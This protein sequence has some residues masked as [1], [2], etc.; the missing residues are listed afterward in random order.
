M[1][2]GILA[3]IIVFAVIVLVHEGGHFIAA[4]LMG[5]KVEE[6]AIG[7]GPSIFSFQKGETKY[8]LR[9]IPLGGYNK[10]LGMDKEESDDPKAFS[11]KPVWKR[12]VVIVAGAAFNVILAFVIFSSVLMNTGYQTFPDEPVIGKVLEGTTAQKQGLKVGDRILSIDDK[13]I[14][15]WSDIPSAMEGKANKVVSLKIQ[16]N[17]ET[18][19]IHVIPEIKEGDRPIMGIVPYL[20]NHK[21]NF[22]Q[23]IV[24]GAQR[25][26]ALL[27]MMGQGLV[28]MIQ[29]N[30]LE[31]SGPIGVARMASDVADTGIQ[32]LLMFIALLSLNL[33]FLN[34]LPIPFL[35]GGVMVLTILEGILGR[36]LPD[37]ALIVINSIGITILLSLFFFAMINDVNGLMK[38]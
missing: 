20:E 25:S 32:P 26:F 23:A 35:D 19:L 12:L 36:K 10:I 17:E 2:M 6:F 21:V 29:G 16:R 14:E 37:K 27:Y 18:L 28:S 9:L 13:A 34:L 1:I 8:S 11:S 38:K 31:V 33:G 4:K 15:K 7:F 24:M 3:P 5:M 22:G 30:N